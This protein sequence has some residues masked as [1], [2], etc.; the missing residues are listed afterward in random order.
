MRLPAS[1]PPIRPLNL[2]RWFAVASLGVITVIAL[3]LGWLLSNSLTERMLQREGEVS[4][5]FIQNLLATDN[6]ARYFS[7]HDD[8]QLRERFLQ[9][10]RHISA[11]RE[12]VRANAYRPDGTVLWSTDK[13]L[14]G[15]RYPVNAELD[16]ALSGKLVVHSGRTDRDGP[17]KEEHVGLQQHATYFVESYI[18]IREPG[19]AQVVGVM[20]LYKV[21]AQL[22]AHIR[23]ALIQLWLACVACGIGLF[24]TLYWLV[25]RAHRTLREQQA[26]L[27]EAQSL[28]S[29]A[30]LASAVAHNLRN[31]LASIRISAEMLEQS[32]APAADAAE[33]CRDIVGAVDRADR[34]IS[35]LVRVAQAPQLQAE[36]VALG[37]LLAACLSE[38]GPEMTR[39]RIAWSVQDS[40]AGTV[41]AHTAILR[42]IILSLM[43]NAIEAM[44]QGGQLQVSWCDSPGLA[45]LRLSDSGEGIPD[46]VRQRLFRPFFST[47][48]GGLGIGLALVKR[49]VE[50]WQGTLTLSPAQ[51]RGTCVEI[52]LPRAP[53]PAA[54]RARLMKGGPHGHLVGD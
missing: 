3:S 50:Q 47:K 6:T 41:L 9:S 5:D 21:P 27:V 44:P 16:E 18:P 17:E 32:D 40:A 20:E 23:A 51:P 36:A 43:A 11:M 37:P 35:E 42:Q 12:P 53:S 15:R 54:P 1:A 31:P 28:A 34:W 29:A 7:Q 2:R 49:M 24:V 33:H 10:M 39:R 25:A 45:G 30:E 52:L 4:M 8:P 13:T 26:Q 38:M 48:S 46:D 14:E 19:S 22:N